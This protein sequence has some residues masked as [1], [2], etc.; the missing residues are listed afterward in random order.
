MV[1]GARLVL[2]TEPPAQPRD[3]VPTNRSV[4][5]A[6]MREAEVVRPPNHCP[7]QVFH[8]DLWPLLS[9]PSRSHLPNPAAD[10]LDARLAGSGSYVG[11]FAGRAMNASNAVARELKHFVRAPQAAG[12]PFVDR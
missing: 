1:P 2:S 10:A 7:V 6:N 4:G 9:V 11:P 5:W 8:R 12:F 3:R